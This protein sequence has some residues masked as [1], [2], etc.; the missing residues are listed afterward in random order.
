MRTAALMS[1][2]LLLAAPLA[3]QDQP[4]GSDA[5][6]G[7]WQFERETPR[8]MVQVPVSFVAEGDSVV[9]MMG[10]GE[11]AVALGAVQ[12]E[13]DSV[14]FPLDPRA[15]MQQM[16]ASRG[17]GQRGAAAGRAGGPPARAGQRAGR[18]AGSGA[19]AAEP[20]S[21]RGRLEGRTI[22][23]SVQT[24]RGAQAFVLRRVEQR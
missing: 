24:P 3:A 8:G 20:L 6:L 5:L 7:A 19:N 1:L 12:V 15:L 17:A 22:T 21:F 2:P 18:G 4:Q 10:E 14:T 23:G 9:A 16:M 13:G 11:E